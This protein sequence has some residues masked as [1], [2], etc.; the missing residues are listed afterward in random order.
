MI[1]AALTKNLVS[2]QTGRATSKLKRRLQFVMI[3]HQVLTRKLRRLRPRQLSHLLNMM[4]NT[5]K[6]KRKNKKKLLQ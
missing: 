6:K 3:D 4:T 1:P 5:T 2:Y